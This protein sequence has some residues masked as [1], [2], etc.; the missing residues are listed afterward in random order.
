MPAQTDIIAQ[1][2]KH[3]RIAIIRLRSLGDCILL[4]PAIQILHYARPDLRIGVVVEDRFADVFEGN[5]MIAELLPPTVRAIRGFAPRLCLNLHGGSRSARLT[6][7]S[8]ADIRA[9]LDIFKPALIYNTPIPTAQ[10]ILGVTRRVHTAEH[11]ASAMFYLGVERTWIPRAFV[12][13]PEGRSAH[14]PAGGYAVLHPLAATPEKTWP[15]AS[16]MEAAE[17]VSKKMGLEPVFIGGPGEDLSS[18]SKWQTVSGAALREV[19]QLM[20]DASLFLGNDSGPAHLA[21]AF[22]LPLVVLFGP[23]DS[24]IWSPWRTVGKVLKAEGPI[25]NIAVADVLRGLERVYSVQE[26]N[27]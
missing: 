5:P 7:L 27:R 14:A 20:R 3:S 10:E 21:A 6:M 4:T 24:E 1:L 15:A 25:P 9:G 18:F 2:P 12:P 19:A 11:M 16:F 26:A 22:G 8:G 17:F 13:A 23:S